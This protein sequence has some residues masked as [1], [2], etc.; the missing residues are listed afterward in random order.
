MRRPSNPDPA[1]AATLR[2]IREQRGL[3]R[4]ALAFRCGV[5]TSALAR[6]E[7]GRV[8]PGWDTVR[9]LARGLD[10]TMVE[11]GAA[12]EGGTPPASE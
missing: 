1:L 6:I 10:L 9:L 7:L 8:S 3:T 2:K 5:T 4:E 12:V 11:L